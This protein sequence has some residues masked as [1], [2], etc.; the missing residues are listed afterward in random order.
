MIAIVCLV[1]L[2]TFVIYNLSSTL[3]FF[4]CQK[5]DF[6]CCR[7]E[8]CGALRGSSFYYYMFMAKNMV[9]LLPTSSIPPTSQYI[10]ALLGVR[11][12]PVGVV[13]VF[14]FLCRFLS[15]SL[16]N[17]RPRHP[18]GHPNDIPQTGFDDNC[19]VS[20]S[21][22]YSDVVLG[23]SLSASAPMSEQSSSPDRDFACKHLHGDQP[24]HGNQLWGLHQD[25]QVPLSS[26]TGDMREK[27]HLLLNK[28]KGQIYS[29]ELVGQDSVIH[30]QCRQKR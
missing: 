21:S 22:S 8:I 26:Y 29:I 18:H 25:L 19:V 9:G 20:R 6:D 7:Q 12:S 3:L 1:Y 15:L 5:K 11:P 30:M 17:I 23:S 24:C 4:S 27:H 14:C 10:L 2:A 28:Q 16:I 13:I